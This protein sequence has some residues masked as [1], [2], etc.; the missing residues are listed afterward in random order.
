MAGGKTPQIL[1]QP[2]GLS[3]RELW[4]C[5]VFPFFL[6][7]GRRNGGKQAC[8]DDAPGIREEKAENAPKTDVAKPGN[9]SSPLFHPQW[10]AVQWRVTGLH[11]MVKETPQ[12]SHNH[13]EKLLQRLSPRPP[14]LDKKIKHGKCQ[15]N[16]EQEQTLFKELRRWQNHQ[17]KEKNV[18]TLKQSIHYLLNNSNHLS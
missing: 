11:S 8:G 9:V 6:F 10:R 15:V 14:D 3:F 18:W 1:K 4:A 5:G 2:L 17:I 13:K 12:E 16:Y 7:W